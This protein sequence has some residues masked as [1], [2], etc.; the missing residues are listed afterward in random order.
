M[1][2]AAHTTALKKQAVSVDWP[3]TAIF[4]AAGL[5]PRSLTITQSGV[6]NPDASAMFRLS[7]A[8]T[9]V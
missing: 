7:C 2:L 1:L 9:P 5:L 4:C 8:L 3:V 6:P